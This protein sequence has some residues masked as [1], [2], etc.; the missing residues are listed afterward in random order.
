MSKTNMKEI[1]KTEIPEIIKISM[2]PT[3]KLIHSN[4]ES[5]GFKTSLDTVRKAISEL[6]IEKTILKSGDKK[7][8]FSFSV[9]PG[10][11]KRGW[12]SQLIR[13]LFKMGPGKISRKN[14]SGMIKSDERNTHILVSCIKKNTNFGEK[15]IG[16]NKEE[17]A[18]TF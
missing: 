5:A 9:T 11:K 15:I 14:L 2:N 16:W 3:I 6:V 7:T 4:L 12:K 10:K 18:Y 13:K 1:V 8:G 17:K